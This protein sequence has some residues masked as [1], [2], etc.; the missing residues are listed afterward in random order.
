MLFVTKPLLSPACNLHRLYATER[1]FDSYP[2]KPESADYPP[3]MWES[4][5]ALWVRA[6]AVTGVALTPGGVGFGS[7]QGLY[8][9]HRYNWYILAVTRVGTPG[10]QIGYTRL[11]HGPYWLSS[12]AVLTCTIPCKVH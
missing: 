12:T 5:P 4:D 9:H 3:G 7:L 2:K 6:A 10:G 1:Y 8:I 11:V